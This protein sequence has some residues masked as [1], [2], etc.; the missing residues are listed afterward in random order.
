MPASV[1]DVA[2][3]ILQRLGPMT[4]MKLQKLVYYAQAWSLAWDNQPLFDQPIEAW[5]YGPVVPALWEG[6]RG[7]RAIARL[8][9]GDP[10][11]LND[12]QRDTIDAVL[13]HYG[14]LPAE[15][16][17]EL[18]HAEAPW[19]HAHDQGNTTP[20]AHGDL[21]AY[22]RQF[23]RELLQA[24]DPAETYDAFGLRLLLMHVTPDNRPTPVEWGPP[25]GDEVW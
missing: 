7:Q 15:V 19:R 2:Q 25:M 17:S 4:T 6:H 1:F 12:Q 20:I 24:W 10:E 8:W 9:Q 16:L 5:D 14:A 13:A 21:A 23:G 3:Y 18:T 11:H 22:Y